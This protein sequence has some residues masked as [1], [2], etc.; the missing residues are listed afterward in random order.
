MINQ[1]GLSIKYQTRSDWI[2]KLYMM[3]DSGTMSSGAVCTVR[4]PVYHG[5]TQF[6]IWPVEHSVSN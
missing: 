6:A 4:L 5:Y 3:S 1:I 2:N